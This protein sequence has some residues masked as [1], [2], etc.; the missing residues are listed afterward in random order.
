MRGRLIGVAVIAVAAP[1]AA[2]DG[3]GVKDDIQLTDTAVIV[4]A[5][6]AHK[7]VTFAVAAKQGRITADGPW[8]AVELD[9]PD[10]VEGIG[11]AYKA[12]ALTQV[13]RGPIGP[14]G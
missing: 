7:P 9:G 14:Q 12:G 5:S 11:L 8:I 4:T 2:V 6:Q 1:A 13:W 10:G 3:D